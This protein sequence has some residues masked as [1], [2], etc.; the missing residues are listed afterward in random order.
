[1]SALSRQSEPPFGAIDWQPDVTQMLDESHLVAWSGSPRMR[2]HFAA[3][4]AH[5]LDSLRD[6]EVCVFYGRFINDLDSFCHQL[7]RSIPGGPLDR[8]IDGGRGI[9]GRLRMRQTFPGRMPSKYRYYVWHDADVLLRD[10]IPLF[11]RL[12]DALMGVGAEAEYVDD[13]LLLIHRVV[14]VG[15]PLLESVSGQARGPFRSWF[16]DGLGDPFWKVVTGVDEPT[17]TVFHI[18]GLGR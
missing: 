16:R 11:W 8:R 18:D 14:Y 12:A 6:V 17:T 3:S 9:T 4:L 2:L 13:D 10:N 5:F 7:E 15:S 1:M